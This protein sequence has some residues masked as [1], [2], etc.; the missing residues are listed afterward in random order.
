M[1]VRKGSDSL[2]EHSPTMLLDSETLQKFRHLVA[3]YY[4]AQAVLGSMKYVLISS[5]DALRFSSHPRFG[6]LQLWFGLG[7]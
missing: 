5:R 4:S 6:S 3:E 1:A 7:P 2:D